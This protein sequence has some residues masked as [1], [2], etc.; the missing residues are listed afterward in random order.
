[1]MSPMLDPESD[2]AYQSKI[3]DA[4]EKVRTQGSRFLD[5]ITAEYKNAEKASSLLDQFEDV[6]KNEN[7]HP[8]SMS[9]LA[10]TFGLTTTFP[11]L[12]SPGVGKLN[13]LSKGINAVMSK[14]LGSRVSQS[15]FFYLSH[16]TPSGDKTPATNMAII[17]VIR[18]QLKAIEQKNNI[19][20][21]LKKANPN[22]EDWQLNKLT[23]DMAKKFF[24]DEMK[25]FITEQA[26]SSD[27]GVKKI[28]DDV[29]EKLKKGGAFHREMDEGD[30][31]EGLFE[32]MQQKGAFNVDVGGRYGP[33]G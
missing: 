10:N 4:S 11:G 32:K 1:M 14:E 29:Y 16:N 19:A 27:P 18:K 17:E 3:D 26:D 21:Q 22:I 2:R 31:M 7:T 24:S 15:I 13:Y 8:L 25:A 33:G 20:Y 30:I 5:D 9:N 28:V 6:L 12:I 23:H